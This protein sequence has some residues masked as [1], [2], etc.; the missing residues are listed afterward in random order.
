MFS[1]HV[2]TWCF[3]LTMSLSACNPIVSPGRSVADFLKN[4]STWKGRSNTTFM[5]NNCLAQ[6]ERILTI[7][8]AGAAR[9]RTAVVVAGEQVDPVSSFPSVLRTQPSG[10]QPRCGMHQH[11]SSQQ[12]LFRILRE[13]GG[14]PRKTW[15]D[16]YFLSW[17]SF[18]LP[19]WSSG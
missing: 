9:M 11:S 3:W 6:E 15:P 19:W 13:H 2:L 10:L 14:I 8:V 16:L 17:E 1:M 5:V 7:R 12:S 18:W 4:V